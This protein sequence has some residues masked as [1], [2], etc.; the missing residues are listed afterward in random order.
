MTKLNRLKMKEMRN[1]MN[2][3]NAIP[4]SGRRNIFGEEESILVCFESIA[5]YNPSN[6]FART[7]LV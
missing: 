4:S 3:G 7:R 6:I 5:F 2:L 1:D